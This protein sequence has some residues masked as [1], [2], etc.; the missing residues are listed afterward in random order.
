M[1]VDESDKEKNLRPASVMRPHEQW[2]VRSSTTN[3]SINLALMRHAACVAGAYHIKGLLEF[4][5]C[6]RF[7]MVAPLDWKM[8]P[9]HMCMQFQCWVS[10]I[11]FS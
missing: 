7:S 5:V 2:K 4:F 8:Q 10:S 6:N 9:R 11:R 1:Q 3:C